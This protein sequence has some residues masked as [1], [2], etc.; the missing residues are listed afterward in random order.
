MTDATVAGF[1]SSNVINERGAT[2]RLAQAF[3]TLVPEIDGSVSCSRSR[4]KRLL[5]PR[6][7]RRRISRALESVETMMTLDPDASFVSEEDGC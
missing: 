2:E 4:N 5:P 6:S 1:V 7:A 3:Q